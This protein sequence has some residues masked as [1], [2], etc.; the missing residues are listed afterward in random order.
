[1]GRPVQSTGR[2]AKSVEMIF[3]YEYFNVE[4]LKQKIMKRTLFMDF[5]VEKE[6]SKINVKREFAAP[7]DKVW[8][9]WTESEILDQWWAPKPWKAKTKSMD[10]N[11]GGF[12]LYTMTGPDGTEIWSK[13]D[14]ISIDPRKNFK[15][16]DAFCDS[17][18]VVNPEFP[19]S[20]WSVSFSAS[21]DSTFVNIETK[22]EKLADLEAII[23]M[24]FKEGFTMALENLDD[25][26]DQ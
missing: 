3:N 19:R 11:V 9:A 18:G 23:K 22:Y 7:L 24:G 10:F 26:L 13:A 4:S 1:M 12:W 15:G 25:L 8:S 5:S 6:N 14:Y 20:E 21:G 2:Y 17:K 16:L